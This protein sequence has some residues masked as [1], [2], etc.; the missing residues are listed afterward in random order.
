MTH[1]DEGALAAVAQRGDG[2]TIPLATVRHLTGCAACT[3]AVAEYRA[4]HALTS[5]EVACPL[6][7]D[8]GRAGS[9]APRHAR[10]PRTTVPWWR[11][12]AT[13]LL[14]AALAAALLVA[15]C[16]ALVRNPMR[17]ALR[18]RARDDAR[19]MTVPTIGSSGEARNRAD[20]AADIA[21]A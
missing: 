16:A 3:A 10:T 13:V 1:L 19:R 17:D 4:L 8:A 9:A 12:R 7:P 14:L 20:V 18:I 5:F 15:R 2:E 11:G 6:D 21:S